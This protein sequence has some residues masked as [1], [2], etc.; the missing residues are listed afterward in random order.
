MVQFLACSRP[1][2]PKT[3]EPAAG[4]DW[5]VSQHRID[6][7]CVLYDQNSRGTWYVFWKHVTLVVAWLAS[8]CFY[9]GS[10]ENAGRLAPAG[11]TERL[12][13]N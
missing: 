11:A 2:R 5:H 10:V 7:L 4:A 12:G 3:R 6:A 8:F 13:F 1:A 9:S